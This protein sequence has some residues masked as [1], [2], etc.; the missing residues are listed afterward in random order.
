[1]VYLLFVGILPVL[2][3]GGGAALLASAFRGNGQPHVLKIV[4]GVVLLLA[5]GLWI[6]ATAAGGGYS[7]VAA[8]QQLIVASAAALVG[9]GVLILKPP[10]G[11]RIAALLLA[12]AYP[13]L[14]FGL[15]LAGS[16]LFSVPPRTG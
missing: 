7:A 1:M 13:L 10:A 9:A 16:M 11:R 4:G 14:L 3:T 6:F 2:G 15:A 12:T 5:T 8:A